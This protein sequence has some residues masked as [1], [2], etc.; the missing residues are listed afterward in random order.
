MKGKHGHYHLLLRVV[1]ISL[2]VIFT[3]KPMEPGAEE[4]A[5]PFRVPIL[6][7]TAIGNY[8]GRGTTELYVTDKNFKLQMEY[9]KASGYTPI[10]FDDLQNVRK[11]NKPVLIAF[12]GGDQTVW[13]AYQILQNME[14]DEFQA[15]ATLFMIVGQ[16]GEKNRLSENQLKEMSDSGIFSMQS[17]TFTNAD[18]TV[19]NNFPHELGDSKQ[20]LT[21]I[22]GKK[23]NA[24]AYPLGKYDI[25]AVKEVKKYYQYGL[26]D[27]AGFVNEKTDPYKLRRLRVDVYTTLALFKEFVHPRLE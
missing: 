5:D 6:T 16:I 23:V 1:F 13:K 24:I 7:Y 8:E 14:E 17:N 4:S 3:W 2:L 22:T 10:T 19:T 27:S 26:T 12:I 25:N 9:L 15:K 20:K 18:L 11:F 21:E